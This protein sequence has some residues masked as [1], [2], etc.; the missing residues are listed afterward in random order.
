M[1]DLDVLAPH[2]RRAKE[3]WSE[4]PALSNH[5]K[6]VA[7]SYEGGGH[8]LIGTIK[9][10]IE[11]VCLTILGEFGKPM[12]SSD[13]STT[14]LLVEALKS[15]GL[16]SSRG[17]SKV[18]KLLS[19]HNRMTDTLS[20]LRNESDPVV[21]GKDGFLDTLTA[22]ER[23][24]FLLTADTILALLLAAHDGTEPD[25]KY[26][27]EPYERFVHLHERV[28]RAVTVE[29]A[30]ED[31]EGRQLV[32]V[33]LRTGSLREGIELR[34]EP[35]RLLYAI[36]R[37]AYTELLASSAVEPEAAPSPSEVTE[38][39]QAAVEPTRVSES[40]PPVAAVVAS[41]EG[42]LSPLKETLVEYLE[43]L[44]VSAGG[45]APAGA[46]LHDSLLATAA[47]YMGLDWTTREPLLASMKVALRRA[48][49]QFGIDRE[50]ADQG[51]EHLISWLK[52][53]AVGLKN[54]ELA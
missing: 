21:H 45:G 16:Q 3:R 48:L 34:V 28:D 1:D 4:A 26:T 7:Q 54:T 40:A 5:Y 41:Y 14:E 24:A 46:S 47:P 43:S 33:T 32:V 50:R 13:P 15:L 8:G 39:A 10:F 38:E 20:E 27:R 42:A 29:S 30:I 49:V 35:S 17:A 44:G 23:R 2:F 37:T 18:D 36:D 12:P 52:I 53:Q 6:T 51:A 25:L 11:C 31:D 22:N 9:S 19:A